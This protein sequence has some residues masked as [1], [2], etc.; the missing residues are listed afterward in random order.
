MDVYV[1]IH[2]YNEV[3]SQGVLTICTTLFSQ[4]DVCVAHISPADSDIYIVYSVVYIYVTI[5][6]RFSRACEVVY[7]AL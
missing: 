3:F 6:R 7:V 2:M 5:L 1:Y 4:V